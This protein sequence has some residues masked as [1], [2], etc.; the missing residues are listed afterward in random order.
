MDKIFA[1]SVA[2]EGVDYPHRQYV[3]LLHALWLWHP[4]R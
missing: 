2:T 3:V 1:R 4:E